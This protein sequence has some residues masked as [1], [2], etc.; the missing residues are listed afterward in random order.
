VTEIGAKFNDGTQVGLGR[1]SLGAKWRF[2]AGERFQAALAP[3]VFFPSPNEKEFAGPDS[4]AL[5][6]RLLAAYKVVDLLRLHLDVGYDH[7]TDSK[8]LRRFVWNAGASIPLERATIDVG[9]GGS[10]YQRGIKWTPD[11]FLQPPANLQFTKLANNQLGTTYVDFLFGAKVLVTK[12][13]VI[14]GAVNVPVND[15]GF[16]PEA[17]GTLTFELYF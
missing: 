12:S 9:I 5:V 3:E 17:I 4:G 15:E 14:A 10:Q 11:A 7:D 1:I 2:F 16:R 8:E 13:S 6:G